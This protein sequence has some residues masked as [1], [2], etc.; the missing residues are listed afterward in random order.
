MSCIFNDWVTLMIQET[1]VFYMIWKDGEF[2]VDG[3][4][5]IL[6][7][8]DGGMSFQGAGIEFARVSRA[9]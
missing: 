3:I 9:S 4:I 7:T 6:P 8:S 5:S 2:Y 1:G